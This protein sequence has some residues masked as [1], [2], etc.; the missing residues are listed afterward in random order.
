MTQKRSVGQCDA[1]SFPLF[2]SFQRKEILRL[3]WMDSVYLCQ[4]RLYSAL[5]LDRLRRSAVTFC[6]ENIAATSI[7][8]LS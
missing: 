8:L 7:R 4:C 3:L 1:R 5:F 2:P 6:S